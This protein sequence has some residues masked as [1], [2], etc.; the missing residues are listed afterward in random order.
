[1]QFRLQQTLDRLRGEYEVMARSAVSTRL[2]K[3]N[4]FLEE[5]RQHQEEIEKNRE[6]ATRGI[7][8]DLEERLAA[9]LQDMA[10]AKDQLRSEFQFQPYPSP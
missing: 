8:V 9:A 5:R 1:M 4:T 7:Q 3:M 10:K 2:R 6:N